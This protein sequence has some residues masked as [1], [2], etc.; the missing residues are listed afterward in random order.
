MAKKSN[1]QPKKKSKQHIE[2]ER[3]VK[4][5]KTKISNLS[6]VATAEVVNE[7]LAR[8]V[9]KQLTGFAGFLREQ[10]VVGLAVGLVLGI[11]VKAVVDQFMFSFIT[12]LLGLVLPGNEEFA[13]E[14]FSVTIAGS[15]QKFVW[16]SFAI[17]L[18]TLVIVAAIIYY[19][20]KLLRLDKLAKKKD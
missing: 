6:P 12:P 11:Q 19:A 8:Q 4:E 13:K 10:G 15:T 14:S 3:Q 5:I 7:V 17:S 9:G 1:N 16:G 18:I 2:K 20:Y